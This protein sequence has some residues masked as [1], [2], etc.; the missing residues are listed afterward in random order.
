MSGNLLSETLIGMAFA[1]W[2]VESFL[3]PLVF[4]KPTPEFLEL[5]AKA[6]IGTMALHRFLAVSGLVCLAGGYVAR[7][8]IE[9]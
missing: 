4:A 6:T 7:Y 8:L 5:K 1:F 2:C 3:K 9:N